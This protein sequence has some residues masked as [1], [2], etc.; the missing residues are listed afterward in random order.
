M[1]K[2]VFRN[3]NWKANRIVLTE[4][5][6]YRLREAFHKEYLLFPKSIRGFFME[7]D[8]RQNFFLYHKGKDANESTLLMKINAYFIPKDGWELVELRRNL[9]N[10][11]PHNSKRSWHT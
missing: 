2:W 4:I 3:H 5:G 9:D 11:G 7:Y 1:S 10:R 8:M 6:E